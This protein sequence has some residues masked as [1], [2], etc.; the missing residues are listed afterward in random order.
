MSPTQSLPLSYQH[1][2][3]QHHQSAQLPVYTQS[4][5]SGEEYSRLHHYPPVTVPA[6]HHHHNR[7]GVY[8][9]TVNPPTSLATPTSHHKVPSQQQCVSPGNK[10]SFMNA[11][12][13]PSSVAMPTTNYSA[14]GSV[15]SK[16]HSCGMESVQNGPSQFQSPE[17]QNQSPP[18]DAMKS[19]S[20]VSSLGSGESVGGAS[21]GEAS[22]GGASSRGGVAAEGA[23]SRPSSEIGNKSDLTDT[24]C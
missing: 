6:H 5:S 17:D 2:H 4:S 24:L 23:G 11:T 14:H 21:S 12:H 9:P 22:S 1:Q 7:G 19:L 8:T 10:N 3:H 18:V 15:G 16:T 20:S 13:P